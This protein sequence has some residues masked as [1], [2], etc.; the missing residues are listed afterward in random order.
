MTVTITQSVMYDHN[1]LYG[2]HMY[3]NCKYICTLV[4]WMFMYECVNNES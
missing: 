4:N 2:I 3:E 1:V